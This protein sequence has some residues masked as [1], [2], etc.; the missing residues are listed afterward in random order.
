MRE[1]EVRNLT[2]EDINQLFQFCVA[3]E[4]SK[5]VICTVLFQKKNGFLKI[6]DPF[7]LIKP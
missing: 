4:D 5:E 6:P 7:I 1:L 2:G 3:K